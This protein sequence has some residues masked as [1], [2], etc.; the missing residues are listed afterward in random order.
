MKSSLKDR[1]ANLGPVRDVDRVLSGSPADL[2]LRKSKSDV[3]SVAAS[4]ALAKRGLSLLRA[5]R[6]IEMLVELG[7]TAVQLPTVESVNALLDDMRASGVTASVIADLPVDVRSI[8]NALGLTQEQFALR[9]NIDLSALRNW[10]QGR[11]TPDRTARSYFRVIQRFARYASA[12]QERSLDTTVGKETVSVFGHLAGANLPSASAQRMPDVQSRPIAGQRRPSL[13]GQA[14]HENVR[15]M[16]GADRFHEYLCRQVG[17]GASLNRSDTWVQ[18][19]PIPG[20]RE[21]AG[22]ANLPEIDRACA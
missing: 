15:R 1:F 5:K 11:Y 7:E 14:L 22:L 2:V 9:F 8:R 3:R 20:P 21:S 18:Y 12:A 19:Q 13:V 6:V 4:L 17:F 10:E 16:I